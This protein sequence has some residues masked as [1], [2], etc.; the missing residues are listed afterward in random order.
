MYHCSSK[1]QS[2]LVIHSWCLSFSLT[3]DCLDM[4]SMKNLV[5]YHL[6]KKI[7]FFKYLKVQSCK[8]F[9]SKYMI[10]S[11]L[12]TNAKVFT[13]IDALVFKILNPRVSFINRKDRNC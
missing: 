8:L 11:T 13:F 5:I 10:A 6:I 1:V 7:V 9:N 3:D 4:L 12:I 2:F